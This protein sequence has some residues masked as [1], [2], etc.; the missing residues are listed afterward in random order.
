MWS[1]GLGLGRRLQAKGLTEPIVLTGLLNSGLVS[2]RIFAVMV[3]MALFST[4]FAMPLA[5]L[6]LVRPACG[7]P[8]PATLSLAAKASFHI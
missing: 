1:F 4:A 3:L 5:R 7:P 8:Q 6:A 2:P